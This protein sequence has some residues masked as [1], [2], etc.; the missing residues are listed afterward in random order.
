MAN[1]SNAFE[2]RR[3]EPYRGTPAR[4]VRCLH[5]PLTETGRCARRA[6]LPDEPDEPP[7]LRRRRPSV[8]DNARHR[9]EAAAVGVDAVA[10]ISSG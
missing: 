6:E 10:V 7:E 5:L 1:W 4:D 2:V 3:P 8:S 9:R